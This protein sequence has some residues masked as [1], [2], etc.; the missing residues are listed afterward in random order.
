VLNGRGANGEVVIGRIRLTSRVYRHELALHILRI[1][2]NMTANR[3]GRGPM[4]MFDL[5]RRLNDSTD[6]IFGGD[7][8]IPIDNDKPNVSALVAREFQNL[9]NGAVVFGG[10]NLSA[11]VVAFPGAMTAELVLD[12][13][14]IG[15]AADPESPSIALNTF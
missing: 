3:T 15:A 4:D 1:A 12:D 14:V 9:S 11:M 7:P 13:Q 5:A 8:V 10:L 2:H 6:P